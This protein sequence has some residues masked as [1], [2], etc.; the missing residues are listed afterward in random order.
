MKATC[1][2]THFIDHEYGHFERVRNGKYFYLF[3]CEECHKMFAIDR[4]N[5]GKKIYD[6]RLEDLK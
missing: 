6:Y 4:D 5:P 3:Y 1:K 2:C